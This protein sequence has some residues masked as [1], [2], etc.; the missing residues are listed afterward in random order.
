MHAVEGHEFLFE[1][2]VLAALGFKPA[3]FQ[4]GISTTELPK[5][6][7]LI[8]YWYST[9]KRLEGGDHSGRSGAQVSSEVSPCLNPR[10]E[11]F[12]FCNFCN[13]NVQMEQRGRF[14]K[15]VFSVRIFWKC[16]AP[17]VIITEVF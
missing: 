6:A 7:L 17:Q 8:A 11:G 5:I 2:Q 13:I 14:A 3:T 9:A 16:L 15:G 4:A 1:V 12:F 10:L